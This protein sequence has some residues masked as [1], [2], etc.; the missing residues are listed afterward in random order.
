MA[1]NGV[2][3]I[4]SDGKTVIHFNFWDS[5]PQEL[6]QL[7]CW[8]SKNLNIANLERGFRGLKT[9]QDPEAMEQLRKV[10]GDRYASSR[11]Y[12]EKKEPL[13]I[14]RALFE[15]IQGVSWLLEVEAGRLKH[16]FDE[17]DFVKDY[18]CRYGYVLNLDDHSLDFYSNGFR[19]PS[20][21]YEFSLFGIE[22]DAKGLLPLQLIQKFS[23]DQIRSVKKL[24][25]IIFLMLD[26]DDLAHKE[27]Q[28]NLFSLPKL[29]H[30]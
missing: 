23:F 7:M 20:Q 1:G 13:W 18:S 30:A 25:E 21:H 27:L 26:Y 10:Y 22:P 15:K 29:T 17:P 3:G 28:Y 9:I 5:Y 14:M 2:S 16:V 11:L 19:S 4:T 12:T 24:E 6:G 8:Y